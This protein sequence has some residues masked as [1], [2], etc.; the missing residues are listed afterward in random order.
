MYAGLYSH[1]PH[2]KGAARAELLNKKIK[3]VH[4]GDVSDEGSKRASVHD[5]FGA[6]FYFTGCLG[7]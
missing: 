7:S 6:Y 5:T 3:K 2:R 4:T 1:L